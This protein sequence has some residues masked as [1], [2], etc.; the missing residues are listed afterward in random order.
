MRQLQYI[1]SFV[2]VYIIFIGFICDV[3]FVVIDIII[4][5]LL[6]YCYS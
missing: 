4:I 6:A 1:C 2:F 3:L 5:C